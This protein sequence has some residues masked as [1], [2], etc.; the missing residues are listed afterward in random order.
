MTWRDKL[1]VHPAADLFPMMSDAEL[2]E[3]GEDIRENGLHQP[4]IVYTDRENKAWLLDG[5]NRLAAMER[6]DIRFTIE[7][8]NERVS[9]S[10]EE[11]EVGD[12]FHDHGGVDYGV[13]EDNGVDPYSYVIGANIHRRHLTADQK[14]DLIAKLLKATPDKSDRQIGKMTKADGKTVASVRNDLEARAEIP[15]VETRADSKQRQQPARKPRK[16]PEPGQQVIS[17]EARKAAYAAEQQQLDNVA[18]HADLMP[19]TEEVKP[20]LYCSFCGKSQ[21]DVR[22]LAQSPNALICDEC[23]ALVVDIDPIQ[24]VVCWKR[25]SKEQR[26]KFLSA[27]QLEQVLEAIPE[28][29]RTKIQTDIAAP[30][31]ADPLDL[32]PFLRRSSMQA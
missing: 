6:V 8:T 27:I 19:P 29:W 3:L 17:A 11:I 15:H 26:S 10:A 31:N 16:T 24:A 25:W 22:V 32:P 20:T 30:A 4:I 14:R 9:F 13:F 5:R 21:H 23:V 18:K 2:R 1:P 7:V 12:Y 28:E